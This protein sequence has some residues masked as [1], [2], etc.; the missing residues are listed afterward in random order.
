MD[1]YFYSNFNIFKELT[2]I[3]FYISYNLLIQNQTKKPEKII[4]L[5]C[6]GR[7]CNNNSYTY[8]SFYG[9]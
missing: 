9:N 6:W 1:T 2:L 4:Q 7:K 3:F 8:K 5:E